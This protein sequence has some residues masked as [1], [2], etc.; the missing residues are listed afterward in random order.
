MFTLVANMRNAI[1]TWVDTRICTVSPAPK[2]VTYAVSRTNDGETG[3]VQI[4]VDGSVY[5][6]T[7]AKAAV[8]NENL[9]T[10][11]VYLCG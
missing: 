4:N 2:A 3:L 7:L 9:R 11:T 10:T 1:G 5:F 6:R 8:S